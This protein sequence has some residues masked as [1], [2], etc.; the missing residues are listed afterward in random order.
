[1][2]TFLFAVSYFTLLGLPLARAVAPRGMPALAMAPALGWA[3]WA[4]LAL[5]VLTLT[6]FGALQATVFSLGVL[7]VWLR[8][9]RSGAVLP[10]WSLAAAA[11]VAALP[12][13]A[14]APKSVGTGILLGPPMF[15]HVKIALVDAILRSGLPVP[16]P[17]YGPQNPGHLA[18]YYLWHFATAAVAC[19]LHAGGWAAEAG[20]TGFT[21]FASV[22]LIMGL[23]QAWGGGRLSVMAA[24]LLCLPGSMRPILRTIAGGAGAD[25]FIPPSADLGGWLNQAAWVP[26]HLASACCA[27]VSALLIL[28]M[29]EGGRAV[30]LVLGLTVAA[31]FE[32]S[33][34]VGGVAFAVA[35]A[36]MGVFVLA[37]MPAAARWQLVGWAAGAATVAGVLILPFVTA[38]LASV[39]ARHLGAGLA[40]LPY[41]VFGNDVP[42]GWRTALDLPGFWLILLPF[43][44]PAVVPL[45]V[46]ALRRHAAPNYVPALAVFAGGCLAAAALLRSTIDNNDLGWRAVLPAVL[47]L[48]ALAA[49]MLE[50]LATRARW[51]ALC[52]G[53]LVACLGIPDTVRMLRDYAGG[54]LPGDAA[55]F[56]RSATLWD[57]VRRHAGALDRVANNPDFV[58]AATPWP[59]NIS[60][61]T[62]ADRPSCY[63]GWET[64]LAYGSLSRPGL[65]AV[66]DRFTRVFAGQA[67][68]GDVAA[69]AR[70]DNCAVAA[71]TAGDGAWLRDPFAGSRDFR[72]AETGAWWRI[73]VRTTP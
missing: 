37:R 73:Y 17:F 64:V 57:A 15:D 25:G 69:L 29:A 26:Q 50:R 67:A 53:L 38:E 62:I 55:G 54:Q 61:A 24:P 44:W 28:R 42:A 39:R 68:P 34:W 35:G 43:T 48:T 14:I 23:A 10:R 30:A 47:L 1:M 41:P 20:M 71:V 27:M 5:P 32:S 21:A 56:A 22:M 49:C 70:T 11:C 40:V 59:V 12:A 2:L 65:L 51:G 16:N 36:A 6:G 13:L 45:A 19:V 31:G 72:L 52:A 4:V 18:Y 63:A 58:A 46:A 66:N 33:I 7:A 3:V 9:G 60:W 8:A